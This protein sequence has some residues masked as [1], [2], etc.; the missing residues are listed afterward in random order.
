MQNSTIRDQQRLLRRLNE[1][2]F[3]Q[4]RRAVSFILS[5]FEF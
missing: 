4:I 2:D 3:M 1:G 5:A